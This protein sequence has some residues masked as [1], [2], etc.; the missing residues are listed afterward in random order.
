MS[1]DEPERIEKV[2]V[3]G[4]RYAPRESKPSIPASLIAPYPVSG[5]Y[6][7]ILL[8]DRRTG[9]FQKLFDGRVSISQFQ[10]GWNTKPEVLVI[11][12][13]DRDSDGNGTMDDNDLHDVYIMTLSDRALHKVANMSTNPSELI[14]IPNVDYIVVKAKIDHDRDGRAPQYSYDED[15]KPEPDMLFRIDLKSFTAAPFVPDAMV[16]DLQKTLDAAPDKPALPT[17]K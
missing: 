9:A 10:R 16:Q 4:S 7:N 2:T 11:F 5:K 17:T 15:A 14:Q 8:F 12:A 3:T 6:S 1:L 13:A